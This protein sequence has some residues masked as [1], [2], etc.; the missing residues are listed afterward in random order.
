MV[1]T[2]KENKNLIFIERK[3][4]LYDVSVLKMKIFIYWSES[5]SRKILKKRIVRTKYYWF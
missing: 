5:N 2:S 3:E 1:I 4:K